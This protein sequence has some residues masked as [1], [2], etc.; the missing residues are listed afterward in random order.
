MFLIP[1]LKIIKLIFETS[2]K[3]QA[4]DWLN[5]RPQFTS[6]TK[7][8][9][10]HT[11]AR[12]PASLVPGCAL[13]PTSNPLSVYLNQVSLF[14]WQMGTQLCLEIKHCHICGTTYNIYGNINCAGWEA[15]W[16]GSTLYAR[17]IKCIYVMLHKIFGPAAF[18]SFFR[19]R[20]ETKIIKL[21]LEIRLKSQ[22]SDWLKWRHW[23][24]NFVA[25]HI[26]I[27]KRVKIH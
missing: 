5:W 2:L 4:S 20:G 21:R 24:K 27:K 9:S 25:R 23:A 10:L 22:A 1:V 6:Y 8:C 12:K 16:S 26:Y 7:R 19:N 14:Q 3:S 18:T 15:I 13:P 17:A 11:V